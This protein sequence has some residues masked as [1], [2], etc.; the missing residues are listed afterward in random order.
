MTF[1]GGVILAAVNYNI[2][3]Q[4][5]IKNKPFL[6]ESAKKIEQKESLFSPHSLPV[7]VVHRARGDTISSV[8]GWFV[9]TLK[10]LLQVF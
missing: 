5:Y 4:T 7:H 10:N 8:T 6:Q 9:K 3:L 2:N 1:C